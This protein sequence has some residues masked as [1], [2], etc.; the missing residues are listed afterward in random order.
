M[1]KFL[2]MLLRHWAKSP[3]KIILTLTAVALGTGILILSLSASKLL[4]EEVSQQLDADGVIL[5]VANGEWDAEGKIDQKRPSEWDSK[6]TDIVVSDIQSISNAAVIFTP[7]FDEISTEGRSYTLRS[8][9]GSDPQY[10]DVF[11]LELLYGVPMTDKDIE[12]G[13]KKVWITEQMAVQ[14]YGSAET[15]IGKWIQ[16]P[17]F[18]GGRGMGK[19][20]QNVITNYSIAGVF[21][22]PEEISRRA[23]GIG[24]LIFP[25]TS[26]LPSGMNVQMMLN[27]MAGVFVV[28]SEGASVE[29]TAASLRQALTNNYGENIDILVWEGSTNGESSYMKELRNTV[30]MFSVSVN[31]LG[32]VLLLTSSLGIFSIM[33]VESLSR[34]REI[35]IERALG[36]S[37]NLILREFWSWSLTL[38]LAGAVIGVILSLILAK[39][40]MNNISPLLGEISGQFQAESGIA[41]SALLTSVAMALGF[42][43]V[44]GLLPALSAVKGNIAETIREF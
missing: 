7:P 2:T 30:N 3:L 36:A 26:L 8:A 13:Q 6:V 17:G 22:T 12:M 23:Y 39:P 19:K 18:M 37:Q 21:K 24:D 38:S 4:D 10:F 31:I 25:Y 42:G 43:G 41:A 40:V 14:L 28:K 44:L 9:V 20:Q 1:N 15:A 27:M 29:Q 16:P 35:A 5:Y 33:V 11:S 34:R 32:I